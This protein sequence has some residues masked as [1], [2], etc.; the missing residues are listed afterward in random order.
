MLGSFILMSKHVTMSG[1]PQT[2]I[3]AQQPLIR[4]VHARQVKIREMADQIFPFIQQSYYFSERTREMYKNN[5]LDLLFQL[6]NIPDTIAPLIQ[7][8]RDIHSKI[9]LNQS[10][11][12]VLNEF[13][14][15]CTEALHRLI[16]LQLDADII[17]LHL[18]KELKK[19]YPGA[20]R[21]RGY[22]ANEI[23]DIVPTY[24]LNVGDSGITFTTPTG[25]DRVHFALDVA[26]YWNPR[27]MLGEFYL[28][29]GM[30][31][32]LTYCHA[33]PT[34]YSSPAFQQFCY[35]HGLNTV[36]ATWLFDLNTQVKQ[37][38][39]REIDNANLHL[40]GTPCE[41]R[42]KSINEYLQEVLH[43]QERIEEAGRPH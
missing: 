3:E 8:L 11:L 24:I 1:Q 23:S 18:A 36:G 10:K 15:S 27:T 38:C 20:F 29:S 16:K 39:H 17:S 19:E 31:N 13:L 42:L 26:Y 6:H 41:Y 2:F 7:Y 35:E 14:T 33:D 28:P 30:Y 12:A 22:H 21:F 4:E 25:T 9:D 37:F 43:R 32:S 5:P 34:V 40:K